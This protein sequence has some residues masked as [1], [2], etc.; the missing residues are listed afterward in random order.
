MHYTIKPLL[1]G[2]ALLAAGSVQAQP[3]WLDQAQRDG[4]FHS[5]RQ[6]IQQVRHHRRPHRYSP[7]QAPR[8]SSHRGRNIVVPLVAGALIGAIIANH[9]SQPSYSGKGG[10]KSAKRRCDRDYRSYDWESDT[11]VT[12]GGVV[13]LCPYVRPY[14]R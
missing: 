14:Y 11:F 1:F 7:Q 3:R 4:V 6:E 12:Y 13:K 2:A 8:R 5:S 9:N 10:Y